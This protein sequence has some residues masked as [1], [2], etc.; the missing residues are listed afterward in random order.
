[1]ASAARP[2]VI[3]L[4]ARAALGANL[5]APPDRRPAARP[6]DL[7]KFEGVNLLRRLIIIFNALFLALGYELPNLYFEFLKITPSDN[8]FFILPSLALSLILGIAVYG[9]YGDQSARQKTLQT[10]F[11]VLSFSL[12][13][14]FLFHHI[15]SFYFALFSVGIIISVLPIYVLE[16]MP[17]LYRGSGFVN[18]L[19]T[20]I[21]G[22]ITSTSIAMELGPIYIMCFAIASSLIAVFLVQ[23]L[24]ESPAWLMLEHQNHEAAH[25]LKMIREPKKIAKEIAVIKSALSRRQ[26][27]WFSLYKNQL[28][29]KIKISFVL[30]ILRQ[31]TGVS[32]MLLYFPHEIFLANSEKIVPLFI[33]FAILSGLIFSAL[34]IDYLGRR[35]LLILSLWVQLITLSVL[36]IYPIFIQGD[37]Q[38]WVSFEAYL[39]YLIGYAAGAGPVTWLL[40]IELMPLKKRSQMT[41]FFLITTIVSGALIY[42]LSLYAIQ[43][44]GFFNL[45]VLVF[46]LSAACALVYSYRKVPETKNRILD[47]I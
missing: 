2:N 30:A 39:I 38:L 41:S 40:S 25:L 35:C 43:S 27:I 46:A 31:M 7:D 15:I 23:Y 4:L 14:C 29:E 17:S 19:I 10:A 47:E 28:K 11:L 33:L 3:L 1:M 6:R 34:N 13:A 8:S 22:M 21:L 26:R 32:V 20:L 45:T 18:A 12:I 37:W 5:Q 42:S 24:I 44:L 36:I 16:I 9:I